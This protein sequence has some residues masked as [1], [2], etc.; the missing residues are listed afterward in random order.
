MITMT[1]DDQ[2]ITV[3]EGTS[4]LNAALDHNIYIPHICHHPDLPEIST[5]KL[6]FVEI[7]GEERPVCSCK[8]AVKDGMVV[9]TNSEE[10]TRLR[11]LAM[12]LILAAHPED[13]STC[14]KYGQ[15]ELQNLI[16]YMNVS[17][18]RMHRRVKGFKE[19]HNPLYIHDMNRCILCGRCVRACHD[20][21]DAGI[22]DYKKKGVETY[23]GTLH[24]KLL[25]DED[26]RFCGAC[27][28]VCPTG[29]IRDVKNY[30][31][32]DKW[33]SLIPCHATCPA[34]TDVPRYVRYVSEGKYDEAA[35]VVREKAPFPHV[36]GHVCNHV[37]EDECRRQALTDPISIRN[38][39]RYAAEHDTGKYWRHQGK[40]LP[41]TH[42]KVCVIGAGPA[43]LTAA[44]YLRKQGH[45]VTIKEAREK[46][47]GMMQYGIPSYRL[48]RKDVDE[49]I[50]YIL[51]SGIKLETNC[52]VDDVQSLKNDFDAI[53]IAVGNQKGRLLPLEG[54]DA[55]GVLTNLTFLAQSASGEETGLGEHVVVLGGGNVAFDCARSAVRLGAKDV[56]VAALEARDAMTADEEE[57]LQAQ[58]EGI[59][60]H[61]ARSFER[62]FTEDSHVSGVGM[63][64]IASFTFDENRR[65]IIEKVPDSYEVIPCDTVIF[66]VGQSCDLEGNEEII[67][68]K[69]NSIVI[70]DQSMT[71]V[72]GIFACGDVVYGTKSVIL[73]IAKAREAASSIDQY[74][75]G[76]GDI[77]EVLAPV[78][79]LNGKIGKRP[80]FGYEERIAPTILEANKRK[81]QFDLVNLGID[82]DKIQKEASRCLQ[83]D[84]RCHITHSKIYSEYRKGEA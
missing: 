10:V 83:C 71:S 15:C 9:R 75:G 22:L 18:T 27:A 32:G 44:Y 54:N 48:P 31:A 16:Q 39:K 65:A 6:C 72:D 78:E 12:E 58:E 14:P 21:R 33:E 25:K 29:T 70:N 36:L 50:N 37:C 24:E 84:L 60:V 79:E 20:L 59:H 28:E 66:A 51:E 68:G 45:D 63:S 80:G 26:C 1:I 23:V 11:N 64:E 40:Q 34:H 77:S 38:I 55:D 62:I 53:L 2:E 4:V 81:D 57:I 47:G 49:E 69:A 7:E 35:A 19:I 56:H 46:A 52:R 74:L 61:P 82:D 17:A 42:K 76:D 30:T 41:D 73:A 8:Q 67:R 13:C 5:C 43:G 3:E